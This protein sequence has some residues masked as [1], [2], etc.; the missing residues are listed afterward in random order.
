MRNVFTAVIVLMLA[1]SAYALDGA[2]F[3]ATDVTQSGDNTF[4]GTNIFNSGLTSEGEV[5]MSDNPLTD[6][7]YIAFN[8]T[9]GTGCEEGTMVWNDDDGTA[10]LGLKGSV[11]CLQTGME[12]VVRGKN[13]TSSSFANGVAV[14]VNGGTG[15]SPTYGFSNA[16]DLPNS[17]SIGL[18]TE[19]IADNQ[20]GYITG[21]GLVRE[22]DTSSWSAGD[23]LY[24]ENSLGGLRNTAPTDSSR[25]MH[26]GQVIRSSANEGIV[27]VHPDKHPYFSELSGP[28]LTEGSVP[29]I[30]A[31]A[32]TTEDNANF[33]WDDTNDEFVV[34]DFGREAEMYGDSITTTLASG[35]FANIIG[36]TNGLVSASGMIQNG[37]NGSV[38]VLNAGRYKFIGSQSTSDETAP[39]EEFHIA[40]AVNGAHVEKCEQ[41]LDISIQSALSPVTTTC[42][43]DLLA[44]DIVTLQANSTGDDLSS[45][46]INWFLYK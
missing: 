39:T 32:N 20:F 3:Y 5:D 22:M 34:K 24:V 33:F 36:L 42:M 7:G 27:F 28:A 17:T 2:G 26:M 31:F 30:D 4:T 35:P 41:H 43:M 15:S 37:T 11:V 6:V 10:N 16:A 46:H 38:T 19:I 45:E 25:K 1:A 8:T 9:D 13:T 44:D 18:A 23:E 29:F 12:M 14:R 21:F 40:P